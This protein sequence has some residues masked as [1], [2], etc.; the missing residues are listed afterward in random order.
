[1]HHLID[2]LTEQQITELILL[3][4]DHHI[5]TAQQLIQQQLNVSAREAEELLAE[6]AR[7]NDIQ[8]SAS[9]QSVPL[10]KHNINQ[11][12][13]TSVEPELMQRPR[14]NPLKKKR[15]LVAVL[16]LILVIFLGLIFG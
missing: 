2:K 1:M 6:F 15:V 4:D 14:Q 10:V 9:M 12:T 16:I 13:V 3:L 7:L 11:S 5:A 8:L